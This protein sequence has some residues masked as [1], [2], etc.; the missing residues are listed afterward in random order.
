M[1]NSHWTKIHWTKNPLDKKSSGQKIHWTK[2]RPEIILVSYWKHLTRS[3]KI[4]AKSVTHGCSATYT[5][6]KVY[7][8]GHPKKILPTYGTFLDVR[9][10]VY[11]FGFKSLFFG[12]NHFTDG[13][14]RKLFANIIHQH[15]YSPSSSSVVN[16]SHI[17]K[18]FLYV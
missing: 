6:Q 14:V 11:F 15:Q 10:K 1:P 18:H 8:L 13:F 2:N 4:L 7:F 17:F 12:P 5:V 9:I 16:T 3:G